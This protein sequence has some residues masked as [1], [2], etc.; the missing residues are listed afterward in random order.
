MQGQTFTAGTK[1]RFYSRCRLAAIA[2]LALVGVPH[3]QAAAFWDEVTLY[4]TNANFTP[5]NTVD[6][7]FYFGSKPAVDLSSFE[8]TLAWNS[9]LASTV[10]SGPGSVDDWMNS[11]S[12]KGSSSYSSPVPQVI[13]GSWTADPSGGASSL[14]STDYSDLKWAVF[15]FDTSAELNVPFIVSIEL[16]NIKNSAGNAMDTGSGFINWAT[17]TPVPEPSIWLT[18]ILG[19]AVGTSLG[20]AKAH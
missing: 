1:S 15:T 19:L 5:G 6:T 20:R 11:L 3:A 8:F 16:T 10:G 7:T 12:G 18:L 17:M 13:K 2:A 4:L 14:I 9:E